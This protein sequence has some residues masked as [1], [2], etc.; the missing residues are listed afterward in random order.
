M[1]TLKLILPLSYGLFY[2]LSLKQMELALMKTSPPPK[3]AA[4]K[5][6]VSIGV[7][8]GQRRRDGIFVGGKNKFNRPIAIIVRRGGGREYRREEKNGG[9]ESISCAT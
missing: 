1:A 8:G 6:C 9:T 2:H 4:E 5:G 3:E 7:D